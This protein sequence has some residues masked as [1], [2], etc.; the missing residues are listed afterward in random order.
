MMVSL[1]GVLMG[2]IGCLVLV[3]GDWRAEVEELERGGELD[4]AKGEL[5]LSR[6]RGR[7][8]ELYRLSKRPSGARKLAQVLPP[9][10]WKGTAPEVS[11][12]LF[13]CPPGEAFSR[14]VTQH[15]ELGRNALRYSAVKTADGQQMILEVLE[16]SWFLLE[17]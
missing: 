13:L 10:R 16:P 11:E 3:A 9:V 8:R 2:L 6:G 5:S 14:L 12:I 1:D 4:R 17:R 7:R 15:L